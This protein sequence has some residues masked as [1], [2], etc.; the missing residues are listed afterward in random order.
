MTKISKLKIVEPHVTC[1]QDSGYFPL[2]CLP[3]DTINNSSIHPLVAMD[4]LGNSHNLTFEA[5]TF[6]QMKTSSSGLQVYKF[7]RFECPFHGKGAVP[8]ES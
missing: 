5:T 2:K 1:Q 6:M 7:T 8:F 4:M 3:G